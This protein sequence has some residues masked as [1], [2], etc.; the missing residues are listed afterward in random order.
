MWA[1]HN[2]LLTDV[3]EMVPIFDKVYSLQYSESITGSLFMTSNMGP[4]LLE[5][6]F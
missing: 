2:L 3:P 5:I 4:C 6:H 1:D